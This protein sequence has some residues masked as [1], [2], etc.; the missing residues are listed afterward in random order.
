MTWRPPHRSWNPVIPT[1]PW[2]WGTW[3]RSISSS[4]PATLVDIAAAMAVF[5]GVVT[6]RVR[7][8]VV[9]TPANTAIAA[10]ISTNVAGGD[11][12]ID[13]FQVPHPHGPVGITGFQLLWGGRQVIP[14]QGAEFL[15]GND[16]EITVEL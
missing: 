5:A 7:T 13:L 6:T 15:L 4:P 2:G 10:A 11:D 9:T 16:D 1:G 14:Y 3:K 12:D 8:L